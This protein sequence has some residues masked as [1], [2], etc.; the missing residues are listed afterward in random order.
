MFF[1]F[2]FLSLAGDKEISVSSFIKKDFQK[3]NV[4]PLLYFLFSFIFSRSF[5]YKNNKGVS[6]YLVLYM[7]IFGYED[8]DDLF[9]LQIII[10]FF[11]MA[12]I[13]LFFCI[14]FI[15]FNNFKFFK[16]TNNINTFQATKQKINYPF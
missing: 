8:G 4:Y 2:Y 10:A 7:P 5:L 3:I 15:W 6:N 14:F 16:T 9:N 11:S 13:L 12:F 1:V